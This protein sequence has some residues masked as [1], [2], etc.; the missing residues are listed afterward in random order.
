M[1]DHHALA[2]FGKTKNVTM[3]TDKLLTTRRTLGFT[4]KALLNGFG[5]IQLP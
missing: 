3:T 2:L 1:T 4:P 5:S